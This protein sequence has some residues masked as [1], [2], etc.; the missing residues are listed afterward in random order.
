[1]SDMAIIGN[2]GIRRGVETTVHVVWVVVGA[3]GVH[4][5]QRGNT[6]VAA[7]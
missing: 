4:G 6:R 1:M 3:V 7:L 5:R 2:N